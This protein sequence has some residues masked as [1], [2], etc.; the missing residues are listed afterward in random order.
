MLI[1]GLLGKAGAG[2]DTAAKIIQKESGFP[3]KIY[4][5]AYKLKE[6][7][8]ELYDIKMEYFLDSYLKETVIEKYNKTPRTILQ[9]TGMALKE[10]DGKIWVRYLM[11]NIFEENQEVSIISD[12]RYKEEV[13]AIISAGGYI[14]KII[15]V[16][17][18][19]LSA[20]EQQHPSEAGVDKI[21]DKK[22]FASITAEEG[23]L[24]TFCREV[25]LAY[26]RIENRHYSDS[27]RS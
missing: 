17:E 20:S 9:Q 26:A 25:K 19:K 22:I 7:C 21:S 23:D 8:C 14:L 15:K 18:S 2:K 24:E 3:S 13:D 11:K 1:I 27:I 4:S 12:V 16:G 5:F 10:I 6:I